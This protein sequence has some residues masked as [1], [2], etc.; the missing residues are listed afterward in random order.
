M[1]SQPV[2]GT[3]RI[4]SL[5]DQDAI[6]HAFDAYPWAK[7]KTFLSGLSAILGEPNPQNP[8]GS[9]AD[10]ATHARIFYYAQR[11]GVQI[12]FADYHAWLA[13]HPDHQPPQLIPHDSLSPERRQHEA[14]SPL[15][16]QHA[17]P[18]ADLYVDRSHQSSSAAGGEPNYPMGFAE[19][20]KLLQEGKPVPGIRQIPN[21]IARDPS[22]KPVGTRAAPKKPW[23]KD[24]TPTPPEMNLPQ[25]LDSD[26][27]P[28]DGESPESSTE[29][30]GA[31]G[32]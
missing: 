27:P 6:Y 29:A 24:I 2:P 30:T 4:R 20:L 21:T 15:S 13:R 10:I 12:D 7:D 5:D 23:E 3:D 26:F 28:I 11:I 31:R 17:A 32:S 1:A 16:W 22:I 19:M 9:P 25:A 8:R 14:P 18:K